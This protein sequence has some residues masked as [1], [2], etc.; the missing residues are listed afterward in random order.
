LHP[1]ASAPGQAKPS[2]PAD[3]FRSAP[4]PAVGTTANIELRALSRTS[5]KVVTGR[6]RIVNTGQVPL[7]ALRTG[8][9]EPGQQNHP[10]I[11]DPLA[12]SGIGLLDGRDNKLYM[13]LQKAQ[14]NPGELCL[15]SALVS[16]TVAPGASLD[17]YVL[18]AAPPADVQQVT[19]V[20]PSAMPFQEVPLGS[21]PLP[22]LPGQPDPA[23][24][25]LA[26]P[27][28]L[29]VTGVAEGLDQSV[30]DDGDDR[31][32]RL[33]SDVLFAINKADLTP[34]AE[35][36]L[37][38]VAKQIDE[39]PGTTV[40]VDGH[41]DTT[42]NDAIN[43]PLS[44]RRAQAV[45]DRLKSLVTRSG[46]T[47]QTAG[48]GSK[49]PVFANDTEEGRRKNRRVTIAFTRSR[50]PAPPPT[51]SV[52]PYEYKVDSPAVEG[53]A[54]FNAAEAS[55]VKVEVNSLHRDTTGVT[56]L[57]WTLRNTGQSQ[58]SFATEFEKDY[59][60]H[61]SWRPTRGWAAG[62]VMMIDTAAK[63]RYEPMFATSGACLCSSTSGY[64]VMEQLAP[65]DSVVLWELYK[66]PPEAR[67]VELQ[68]P[69]KTD[70][71][72]ADVTGLSIK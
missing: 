59:L 39:S 48:H 21:G 3:V 1:A 34:R 9:T 37:G 16:K 68:I 12:P 29:P 47:F 6:F 25:P 66:T 11:G 51:A 28:I 64:G 35:T 26:P 45:A 18:F 41:T 65:G 4:L 10:G 56:A 49:Q 14:G 58:V 46:V 32:V 43:Q 55:A 31:S 44:Q 2:A 54:T 50:P 72:A 62:G 38:Q 22:P 40:K 24:T 30:N 63:V 7:E 8:L 71:K 60:L 15:C 17:L 27:R 36:L 70:P 5:D 19:V 57:I 67:S 20:M 13:P 42:G 23:T 52:A 33:A 69:W 61:G 53:D